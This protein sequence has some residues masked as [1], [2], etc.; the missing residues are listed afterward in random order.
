MDFDRDYNLN[1]ENSTLDATARNLKIGIPKRKKASDFP[2]AIM[3]QYEKINK[4]PF[5]LR[6]DI[7]ELEEYFKIN[8]DH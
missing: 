5:D 6:T 4:S 8:D 7:K 3:M 1:L 2:S